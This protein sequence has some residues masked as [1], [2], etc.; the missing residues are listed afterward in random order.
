MEMEMRYNPPT[1]KSKLKSI[2]DAYKAQFLEL[3][4][5]IHDIHAPAIEE[6]MTKG[7]K[8]VYPDEPLVNVIKFF[9]SYGYGRFPVVDRKKSKLVGIITKSDIINGVLSKL[10]DN[11]YK[12]E[13]KRY[14]AS[15]IFKDVSADEINLKLHYII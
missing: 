6:K 2:I 13:I 15:H 4:T 1:T 14:R 3:K 10:E 7:V 11:Y 5:R 8:T 12:E 9:E